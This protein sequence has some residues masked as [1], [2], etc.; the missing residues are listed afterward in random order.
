[1]GERR[2]IR[3]LL[4]ANAASLPNHS[5]AAVSSLSL[6]TLLP[7]REV[8]GVVRRGIAVEEEEGLHHTALGGE[9]VSHPTPPAEEAATAPMAVLPGG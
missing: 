5:I 3:L 1:M 8:L 4:C 9:A 6:P 2:G 7:A